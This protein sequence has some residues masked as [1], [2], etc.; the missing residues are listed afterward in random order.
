MARILSQE[1]IDM[2]LNSSPQPA[3]GCREGSDPQQDGIVPY[4]FR[5]P[6]RLS[7]EQIR[8]LHLLHDRFARDLSTSLSAYLRAGTD[9]IIASVE[10]FTYSEFLVT[11]PDP[12]AFYSLSL[13]PIDGLG[14]LEVDP[15]T[16]FTMVDRMLGGRG[17]SQP[18]N[19]ALTEIE[20]NVVDAVV[21]V[22]LDNLAAAWRPL[23]D[24]QFRIHGRETRPQMLRVAAA[25]EAVLVI[26]FEIRIAD[27]KGVLNLC[28]PA[29]VGTHLP[30]DWHSTRREPS[31]EE[32]RNLTRN[33]ARMRVPVAAVVQAQL[34]A[35]EV[36]AL[37]PGDVVS[38]GRSARERLEIRVWD[39]TK[40]LGNPIRTPRGVAVSVETALGAGENEGAR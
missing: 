2:L 26:A 8:S 38:L 36:L 18:L 16:A 29:A 5:R 10:Q 28:L 13:A 33:L 24:V 7:K 31:P 27:S 4:N 12:T 14:A 3:S 17:S 23:L 20:Q 22:I 37:R 40:F 30:Q 34:P 6:D 11:L 15:L 35:R 9:V 1:E 39:T 32:S 19:R 21:K 25:N